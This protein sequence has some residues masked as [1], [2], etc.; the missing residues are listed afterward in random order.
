VIPVTNTGTAHET[1]LAELTQRLTASGWTRTDRNHFAI[2]TPQFTHPGTPAVLTITI[3]D[4]DWGTPSA[5]LLHDDA[6][7]DAWWRV[8][9]DN[10]HPAVLAAAA[11]AT[12]ASGISSTSD[13]G[14]DRP[15]KQLLQEAG[16]TT[17]HEPGGTNQILES[18][19]TGPDRS[20]TV[21]FP[22]STFSTPAWLIHRA[23]TATG[24]GLAQYTP[25]PAT[26]TGVLAALALTPTPT[27]TDPTRP[28]APDVTA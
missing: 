7:A 4:T 18:R 15:L 12:L 19:W 1:F 23:E 9:C 24:D 27:S 20:D 26:P 16:W 14:H 2:V 5:Y 13:G 17:E 8:A 21:C 3:T 10:P 11:N 25:T 28:C 6:D 22:N